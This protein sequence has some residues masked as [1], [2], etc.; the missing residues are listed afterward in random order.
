[1]FTPAPEPAVHAAPG[2]DTAGAAAVER[3]V[4]ARM[5]ARLDIVGPWRP[6]VAGASYLLPDGVVGKDGGVDVIVHFHGAQVVD[7]EWRSSGVAAV[8]VSVTLPGYGV[9]PYREMFALP[10][11]FGAIIDDAVKR[12]GGKRVR[13]LGL[14]S[15]SAGY[16]ATQ[17]VL[18]NAHYYDM[19]DTVVVFDGMHADYVEGIPDENDVAIFERFARDAVANPETRQMI[20]THSAVTPPG[21]ASTTETATMLLAAAGVARVEERRTNPRGMLEWYHAD[22]GGLHVRGFRGDGPHDHMDQVHL[23]RDVMRT[24]VAPRW[25]RMAVVEER[26]AAGSAG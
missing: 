1:M 9:M 17:D 10:D 20:V 14:V 26:R 11:T 25:T 23:L 24:F 6:M 22:S 19:V 15:W 4:E 21:Y 16:G 18:Q 8:I 7:E 3:E 2:G 5:N 13:R 12:A